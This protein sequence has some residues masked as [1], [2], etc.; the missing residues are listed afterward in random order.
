MTAIKQAAP[1]STT[2]ANVFMLRPDPYRM[3]FDGSEAKMGGSAVSPH[4]RKKGKKY[5]RNIFEYAMNEMYE[6]G[7]IF[8]YLYPFS[9]VYYRKF[10]YELNMTTIK[11]Q[12]RSHRSGSPPRPPQQHGCG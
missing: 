8:S 1:H 6:D 2:T 7:Y 4:F 3:I 9:H 11:I 12:H 5:I 10:G